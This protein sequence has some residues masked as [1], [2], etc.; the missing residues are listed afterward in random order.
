MPI[1]VGETIGPAPL[2]SILNQAG[3]TA[4]EFRAC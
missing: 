3:L 2:R 4:G 1:H